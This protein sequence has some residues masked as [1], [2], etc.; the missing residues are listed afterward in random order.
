MG[1]LK[2]LFVGESATL[3][4]VCRPFQLATSLDPNKYEACFAADNYF[5]FVFNDSPIKSFPL[6][7]RSPVEFEK[8]LRKKGILFDAHLLETYVR[9]EL[10]LCKEV[11]PD[12]VVG[13]LRPSL[14]VTCQVLGI[15]LV[16]LTNAYWS[17]L[18][19]DLQFPFPYSP[20]LSSVRPTAIAKG[21]LK[22][23]EKLIQRSVPSILA[24]QGKGINEVLEKF[25]LDPFVDYLTG[26]TWGNRTIYCDPRSLAP[27]LRIPNTH[28][29]IGPVTWSP[30]IPLPDW[31][32]DVK[33]P[34]V[35]ISLGSSG[36]ISLIK[37]LSSALES[38][39]VSVV[40]ATAGKKID[41][42]LPKNF[43]AA[44][45]LPGSKVLVQAELAITNG[46][47]PSS[48]QALELGVPVLGLPMNMDQLLCMQQIAKQGS[49]VMLRAD[50]VNKKS[51]IKAVESLMG[52]SDC[53]HRAR[54]TEGECLL[55]SRSN[56]FESVLDGLLPQFE[57][58]MT[59]NQ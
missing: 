9:D 27:N 35:Y 23:G 22:L 56:V 52:E 47:S 12:I 4:H 26:F 8:I 24:A 2:V 36:D 37:L 17:P 53:R 40:I 30:K 34:F 41:F 3:A 46:G 50:I 1:R 39:P 5:D 28:E 43:F 14:A 32:K 20:I 42:S 38:F 55:L 49:G 16:T 57:E 48:Y 15:P 51:I 59:G 54:L 25:S 10:R 58:Q 45:Y 18:R 44:D 19:K 29:F 11:G 33:K 31:W 13:D 6:Y 21:I 7:S